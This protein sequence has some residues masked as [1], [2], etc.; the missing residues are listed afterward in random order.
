MCLFGD[1]ILLVRAFLS[2]P[3]FP[4]TGDQT[5]TVVTLS[6]RDLLLGADVHVEMEAI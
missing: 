4:S 5:L 6:D 1:V 3:L 2:L